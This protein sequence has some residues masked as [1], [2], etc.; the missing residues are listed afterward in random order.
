MERNTDHTLRLLTIIAWVPAFAL[1]L[2]HGIITE[3]L[4]PVLGIIPM[5]FSALT[6]LVHLVGKAK[7]RAGNIVMDLFCACF[8]L[9]ILIPG[10][11]FMAGDSS[12]M[13]YSRY[14]GYNVAPLT[15]VGTY[16]MVP[17]VMSL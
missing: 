11:V 14:W 15:M 8:L 5:T 4:C 6:G 1:L 10:W 3:T 13:R 17:M 16:G 9:S 7:Y 12:Y 2:P